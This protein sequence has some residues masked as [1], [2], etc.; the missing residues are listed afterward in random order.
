MYR[1][2]SRPAACKHFRRAGFTL[3]SYSSCSIRFAEE[4]PTL[5]CVIGSHLF[6]V[7]LGGVINH[8]NA[9]AHDGL[10]A[11]RCRKQNENKK[12]VTELQNVRQ[13]LPKCCWLF[14]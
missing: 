13:I 3:A 12:E 2:F 5:P 10:S 11:P 8:Q 14:I 4:N 7:W 9:L 1:I 6:R